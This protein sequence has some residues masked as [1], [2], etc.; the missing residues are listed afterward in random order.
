MLVGYKPN[1]DL[2]NLLS[3]VKIVLLVAAVASG[4]NTIINELT[5]RGDYHYLVSDTTREPRMNDGQPEVNG[6]EY[7]FKKE[8]EALD[9][10][11]KGN[12]LGPAV[13]HNQQVSGIHFDELKRVYDSGK[14][15]I[16]DMD[17]Q[18]S[19]DIAR[20]KSDVMNIFIL[21]PKFNEWMNRLNK[22]GKMTD[23]EKKRRLQSASQE[24]SEA[25]ERP[26]LEMFINFELHQ[27]AE[28]L[29]HFI[30]HGKRLNDD[31]KNAR[32]HARELLEELNSSI[33]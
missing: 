21:P 10:I 32:E 4:R 24:I 33:D 2:I 7:W 25:L 29:D 3:D 28:E 6:V 18:G 23:S 16:T 17:I 20:Y 11:L 9:G 22:R 26:T 13:I 8:T 19:K 14:I 12:Y 31:S 30:K 1:N 15:A 5:K 27:T